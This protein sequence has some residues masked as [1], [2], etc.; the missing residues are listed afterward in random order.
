M[1]SAGSSALSGNNNFGLRLEDAGT[2]IELAP[3]VYKSAATNDSVG[4]ASASIT[5]VSVSVMMLPQGLE[6][7][8]SLGAL[9]DDPRDHTYRRAYAFSQAFT[10]APSDFSMTDAPRLIF[11]AF[12]SAG[13]YA[14]T[15]A[16]FRA[17]GVV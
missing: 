13:T 8:Y 9:P 7:G 10:S 15:R 3:R 1:A 14:W 2:N 6:I 5:T 16:R 11:H 17:L 4:V 12:N